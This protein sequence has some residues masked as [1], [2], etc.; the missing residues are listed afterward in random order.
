M[1]LALGL[2][3]RGEKKPFG[4][5]SITSMEAE[6]EPTWMSSDYG[7]INMRHSVHTLPPNSLCLRYNWGSVKKTMSSEKILA[8][9]RR[10]V[11]Y[12]AWLPKPSPA[13]GE[14]TLSST[15]LP[16]SPSAPPGLGPGGLCNGG[17]SLSLPPP[18]AS[19]GVSSL[20]S[21]C[22]HPQLVCATS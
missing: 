15:T 3:S 5:L 16:L 4:I 20:K 14:K 1:S 7:E 13:F 2:V 19:H 12:T 6:T 9:Y 21:K 11:S 17:S 10:G 18:D 8:C 22:N